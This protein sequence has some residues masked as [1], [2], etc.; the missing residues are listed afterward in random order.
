MTHYEMVKTLSIDD[1]AWF[2]QT[3]IE[4]TEQQMLDKL[5]EYG[6]EVSL[7]TLD[8]SIRHAKIVS[9][10]EVDDGTDS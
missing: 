5:L 1:M 7:V 6:V 3:I 4:Q 2:V 9:D 8:P 10:L